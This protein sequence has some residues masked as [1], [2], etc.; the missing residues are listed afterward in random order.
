MKE[1]KK[2]STWHGRDRVPAEHDDGIPATTSTVVLSASRL[3][4]LLT[5]TS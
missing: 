3:W 4:E 1:K 2:D 5:R